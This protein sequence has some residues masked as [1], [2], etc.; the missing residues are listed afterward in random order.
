[1]NKNNA[2]RKHPRNSL[3]LCLLLLTP[4]PGFAV[5]GGPAP[6]PP[7]TP[8]ATPAKEPAK[9]GEAQAGAT[10]PA[11]DT[12][13]RDSVMPEL[14]GEGDKVLI[15]NLHCEF[16][17]PLLY[18]ARRALR[19]VKNDP[20]IRAVIIDMDT[21]GGEVGVL[22][23]I[24]GMIRE[25]RVPVYLFINPAATSAGALLS[26]ATQG[27]YL[28]PEGSI[29]AAAPVFRGP[30]GFLKVPSSFA[31]KYRSYMKGIVRALAQNNGY[32]QRV[33]EAMIDQDV[34]Y[35]IGDHLV[36]AKGSL[37][38]LTAK[39]AVEIMPDG[40]PLHGH[41][42]VNS[43][44][45][46]LKLKMLDKAQRIR[47]KL[48]SSEK[49][50]RFL[51]MIAPLLMLLGML[52]FYVE[53][54]T[55]G[56]GLPGLVAVICFALAM[57]GH[58]VA[59]LA[60]KEDLLLLAVG[61]TLL[62]IEIFVIP[63]FGV[64]GVLGLLFM[65]AGFVMMMIP[66]LPSSAPEFPTLSADLLEHYLKSALFNLIITVGLT[67]FA[68]FLLKKFLPKTAFYSKLVLRHAATKEAGYTATQED[69]NKPLVGMTGEALSI[70]RPSGIGL[71]GNRRVDVVTRGDYLEKG[72]KIIV[73][74][75][76]GSRIIVVPAATET[77][78]DPDAGGDKDASD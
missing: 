76:K 2:R 13:F 43:L 56:I 26:F 58:H 32:R 22:M 5:P 27:I 25:C 10:A 55:P 40:K 42:I 3:L 57:F 67:A 48:S 73:K 41:A 69:E 50:A 7:K 51:T 70:L 75:V 45:E 15:F 60:G 6:K 16:N 18:S 44:D 71:F 62:L 49:I 35:K 46:L 52:G 11:A 66:H 53:I 61:V 29:G 65:G 37:L 23:E 1:M 30:G 31:E 64:C 68:I 72:E 74:A 17:K 63:G 33:G 28:R 59:G 14:G 47:I 19:I 54:R 39:E 20:A 9:P 78:P 12:P 24:T 21:P 8:K 4:L 34:E 77:P 38:T 36:S